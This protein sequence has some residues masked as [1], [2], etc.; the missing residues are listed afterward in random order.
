MDVRIALA[1]AVGSCNFCNRGELNELGLGL[2]YPYIEVIVF[3]RE[4]GGGLTPRICAD[5]L[6]EFFIKTRIK[7][8]M[9]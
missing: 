4:I 3:S 9:T 5:C 7:T 2:N 1:K 8:G 6:D